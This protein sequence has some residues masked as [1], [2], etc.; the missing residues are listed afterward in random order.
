MKTEI[1][2]TAAAALN[3]YVT[4]TPVVEGVYAT[5]E[6]TAAT[7][8][9]PTAVTNMFNGLLTTNDVTDK[10]VTGVTVVNVSANTYVPTDA[11]KLSTADTVAL[12]TDSQGNIT[13]IYVTASTRTR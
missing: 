9:D 7:L 8:L 12:V 4:L 13:L 5:A 1:V 2:T 11:T 3:G 10:D 6:N